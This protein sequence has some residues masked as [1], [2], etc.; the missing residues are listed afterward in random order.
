MDFAFLNA[1]QRQTVQELDRNILLLASA[2]TGKTNTL[3]CRIVNILEQGRA[4]PEEIICLTFTNKACNEMKKRIGEVAGS[5]GRRVTVKTFHGF[6][7]DILQQ[8]ARA[9]A[10]LAADFTVFDE[11]DCLELV[12][13]L[14][15]C[16]AYQENAMQALINLIKEYRGEYN[17]FTA[18]SRED[19]EKVLW[20]LKNEKQQRINDAARQRGK[21]NQELVMT[22][23]AHCGEIVSEYD[24]IL[25]ENHAVDFTDLLNGAYQL[26]QDASIARLWQRRFKFWSV[27]EV[28][29]TSRLEYT[30]LTMMFGENNLL[31]C[32]DFFQTIYEWRG[33]EPQLLYNRFAREYHPVL[34][35]FHENYRSTQKLL[36]AGYG[37]LKKRF[38]EQASGLFKEDALA[39]SPEEGE[40]IVHKT[41]GNTY[42]EANWIYNQ[43]QLLQP[44]DLSQVC[45]LTRSNYYNQKLSNALA[46][47]QQHRQEQW[48]MGQRQ[49]PDFPLDF[50]LV[51]EFK[52]FRRQEIK[53]VMAALRL[54]L[55]PQDSTSLLRL[56]K[57]FGRRIGPAALAKLQSPEYKEA[58]IRLT[59]FLHS[60]AQKYAEPFEMLLRALEQGQ[61]VVFD[62]EATGLD[63]ARD[64]IIQLAAVK[65]D[66]HG[67]EQARLMRY[68]KAAKP[69]G[70][71]EEIHHISDAKL[72]EEGIEPAAALQEFLDFARGCVIVGHNVVFDLTIL[73]SQLT[74]CGLPPLETA[75]FYDTLDVFRRFYPA[76][77]NHRLEFLGEYCQV[78][79]KSSHDAFDDICAT[80]E[81]LL[82]AVRRNI[83]PS[84]DI[85]RTCISSYVKKFAP[86]AEAV[87]ELREQAKELSLGELA[88]RVIVRLGMNR[89][90]ARDAARLENLRSL[91]RQARALDAQKLSHYDALQGF[92]RLAALSNTELD[93]M[94]TEHPR[95][96][97]ITVHQAKGSEFETVFM[98]GLQE[99]VFPSRISVLQDNMEEEARLFYV[100]ITR[101]RKR[102]YLSTV[103]EKDAVP[104]RF[105]NS[106]PK[107]Y[108]QEDVK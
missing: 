26:L 30:I 88:A 1:K 70:S 5:A 65:L 20:R 95:I 8:S 12:R 41:L 86:L 87:A 28:Q 104:C 45:I 106:I 91:V 71:S 60:S 52:F 9:G 102:L 43:L 6:C 79:H 48:A 38:P 23:E 75:V 29:D 4:Q 13:S 25:R 15:R 55:N 82:Y 96:P 17:I 64:E 83:V 7:Y 47:I 103:A 59:D 74:R 46:R 49:Q 72:A 27:D 31:L 32:G 34:M 16:Q 92:L 24:C 80:G 18:N 57:R 37:F 62:V 21:S 78:E 100:G 93:L 77:P 99:G 61:A 42:I 50:M 67:H 76:L 35:V 90:Y 101:A 85:R 22:F 3:S 39:K 66:I 68:L 105:I 44:E 73:A 56:L 19:Y 84:R 36:K 108:I 94:L 33:S 14:A 2:G 58:G 40:P 63:T 97:I 98:A 53:D 81:I 54:L 11:A 89:Y 107:E 51:D 69:V 10:D